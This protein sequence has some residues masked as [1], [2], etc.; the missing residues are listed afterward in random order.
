MQGHRTLAQAAAFGQVASQYLHLRQSHPSTRALTIHQ[1]IHDDEGL[2][3]V[4]FE[5]ATERGHSWS[6]TGSAYGGDDESYSGEGR[7]YCCYCGADG[8]A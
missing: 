7:C 4:Q 5:C 8:D 3:L 2:T 1:Y 6:Y